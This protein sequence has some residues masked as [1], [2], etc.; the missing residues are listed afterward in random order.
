MV[1]VVLEDAVFLV[2]S[3]MQEGNVKLWRDNGLET[4]L[5]TQEQLSRPLAWQMHRSATCVNVQ[6]TA[7]LDVARLTSS[8]Q[9][10]GGFALLFAA[11]EC[12]SWYRLREHTCQGRTMDFAGRSCYDSRLPISSDLF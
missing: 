10:V 12:R 4:A 9:H 1:D 2:D 11:M 7:N 6:A 8:G 5:T 3:L